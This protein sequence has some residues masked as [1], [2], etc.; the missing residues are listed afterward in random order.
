MIAES[1]G[2][3]GV[4]GDLGHVA[5]RAPSGPGPGSGAKRRPVMCVL[6]VPFVPTARRSPALPHE[7]G[8]WGGE[9]EDERHSAGCRLIAY[10]GARA[11]GA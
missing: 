8:L 10:I 11:G 5:A 6:R 3:A 7:Y 1:E 4:D 9:S 2:G